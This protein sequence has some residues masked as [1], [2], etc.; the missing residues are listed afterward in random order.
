MV[1]LNQRGRLLVMLT[2]LVKIGFFGGYD[3]KGIG[4][5]RNNYLKHHFHNLYKVF[6][7]LKSHVRHSTAHLHPS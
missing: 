2:E 7:L 4:C 6:I 3:N 5:G 1:R